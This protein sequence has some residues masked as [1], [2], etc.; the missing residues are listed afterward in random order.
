M[1]LIWEWPWQREREE[2]EQE[3][4]VRKPSFTNSLSLPYFLAFLNF[5]LSTVISSLCVWVNNI[6]RKLMHRTFVSLHDRGKRRQWEDGLP[7]EDRKW[8]RDNRRWVWTCEGEKEGSS[9]N[10]EKSV[11]WETRRKRH[12]PPRLPACCMQNEQ[13]LFLFTVSPLFPSHPFLIV[14]LSPFP[15]HPLTMCLFVCLFLFSCFALCRHQ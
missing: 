5:L 4:C 14:S 2:W 8:E 13:L 9:N 10:N 12:K 6:T 3:A 11:I 1:N 7:K 15:L